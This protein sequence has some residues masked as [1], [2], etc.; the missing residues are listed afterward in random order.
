MID[1]CS[2]ILS[3]FTIGLFMFIFIFVFKFFF[4]GFILF[5]SLFIYVLTVIFD[6]EPTK[7]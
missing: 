5:W 1:G 3:F 6:F 7:E 4:F 2:L